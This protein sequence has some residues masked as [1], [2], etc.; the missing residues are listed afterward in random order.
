[1]SHPAGL[2]DIAAFHCSLALNFR[3]GLFLDIHERL[4]SAR[5]G[6]STLS[7]L[8]ATN[9]IILRS[10]HMNGLRATAIGLALVFASLGVYGA[11]NVYELQIDG[12]ACPFCAYGIE[13]KLSAIAGVKKIEVDIKKGQVIVIMT[14]NVNLSEER[15]RQAVTDAGFTLRTFTQSAGIEKE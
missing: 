8:Y 4:L 14:E 10:T 15:A 13:K 7:P 11:P 3:F 6:H 5:S 9:N 1:V 2:T 12:L